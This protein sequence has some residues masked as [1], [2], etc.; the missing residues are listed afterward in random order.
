MG[1]QGNSLFYLDPHHVRPAVPF[2]HPP[3]ASSFGT[4]LSAEKVRQAEDDWY[5]RAYTEQQL[6]TFHCERVR[7]MPIRSLDPSM[8]LGFLCQ[9]EAQLDDLC[10]RVR[11]VSVTLMYHADWHSSVDPLLTL[12]V[13]A[14]PFATLPQLP[15]PI[16]SFA[17]VLPRWAEDD[18]FDPAME[19]FS[20]SSVD[21]GEDEDDRVN[22]EAAD[23]DVLSDDGLVDRDG[24]IDEHG[25]DAPPS[26]AETAPG[27][28]SRTRKNANT[29]AT[30]QKEAGTSSAGNAASVL[31]PTLPRSQ[32]SDT[33]LP[34]SATRP[35][36]RVPSNA[37]TSTEVA[38]LD[39]GPL[40][41]NAPLLE[42]G[43]R[44]R[45]AGHTDETFAPNVDV[46]EVI[47]DNSSEAGWEE[48]DERP[49]PA[50]HLS[51]SAQH[52]HLSS[53]HSSTQPQSR[54]LLADMGA[55]PGT[56]VPPEFRQHGRP[57]ANRVPRLD[58]SD[59]D[60]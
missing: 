12:R 46:N 41:P 55:V 6:A 34:T 48:L 49:P 44:K 38:S 50:A 39:S 1:F 60:F 57:R 10:A 5:T 9:D 33:L 15:K 36:S 37:S 59:D 30:L 21:A 42:A 40:A 31:S 18:D 54:R 19:S 58:D 25:Q 4:D 14:P 26:P 32:T 13:A 16:F 11:A 51:A 35:G 29:S 7:R 56:S 53:V 45:G 28:G 47:G 3:P 22:M 17:D 23:T 2:R 8:L 43:V 27:R 20:E 24:G 52:P